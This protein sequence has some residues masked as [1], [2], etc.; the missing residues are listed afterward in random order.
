[1][2]RYGRFIAWWDLRVSR[3]SIY[4]IKLLQGA[5]M[6]VAL[7]LAKLVPRIMAWDVGWFVAWAVLCAARPCWVV[8]GPQREADSKSVQ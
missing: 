7:V 5:A 8:F 1:M 3:F 6:G 2:E 4:D